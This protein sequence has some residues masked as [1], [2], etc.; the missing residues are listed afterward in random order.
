MTAHNPDDGWRAIT[1]DP[2][3]PEAHVNNLEIIEKAINDYIHDN[4]PSFYIS[5]IEGY[6][7][8][9]AQHIAQTLK[10]KD[11]HAAS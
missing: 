1:N 3:W 9:L 7:P 10:D 11:N 6:I 4:V 8:A 5:A 2:T